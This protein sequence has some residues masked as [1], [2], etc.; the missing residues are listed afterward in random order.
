[1]ISLSF[2]PCLSLLLLI[3]LANASFSPPLGWS[4]GSKMRP[5]EES[6]SLT[7]GV[8]KCSQSA[9]LFTGGSSS[10]ALRGSVGAPI[11][12]LPCSPGQ[13]ES[14]SL[15]HVPNPEE[16]ASTSSFSQL[17]S[18]SFSLQVGRSHAK[19]TLALPRT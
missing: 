3:H 1:M 7:T 2:F 15:P 6:Y 4:T 9:L 5:E 11:S 18:A 10:W 14:I 12:C 16:A 19:C 13:L 8:P 17:G